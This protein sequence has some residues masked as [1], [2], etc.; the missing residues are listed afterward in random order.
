MVVTLDQYV[1]SP[2]FNPQYFICCNKKEREKEEKEERKK[3]RQNKMERDSEIVI[4]TIRVFINKD[5][6]TFCSIV[7]SINLQLNYNNTHKINAC[8]LK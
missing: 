6:S 8:I 1:Q 3:N 5:S 4:W 2:R 7:S